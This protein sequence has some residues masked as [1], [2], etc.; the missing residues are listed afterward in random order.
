[1]SISAHPNYAQGRIRRNQIKLAMAIGDSR[2]Y[3]VSEVMPRHFS[4]SAKAAGTNTRKL[5]ELLHDLEE[6]ASDALEHAAASIPDDVS[7]GISLPI[8]KTLA[9]NL[10][11]IRAFLNP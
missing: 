5:Q 3:V 7:D 11:E 4:Q 1:M 8:R 10:R 6:S 2:H 9:R